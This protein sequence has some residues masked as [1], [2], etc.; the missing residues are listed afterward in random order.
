M[1]PTDA[2]TEQFIHAE[3]LVLLGRQL[4]AASDSV[5]RLQILKL[6]DEEKAKDSLTTEK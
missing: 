1:C 3:N 4:A 5:K 6:L 2:A